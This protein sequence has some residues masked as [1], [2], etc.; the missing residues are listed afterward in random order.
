[1]KKKY[2]VSGR[3]I[4]THFFETKAEARDLFS[5]SR[6]PPLNMTQRSQFPNGWRRPT[7]TSKSRDIRR[8][9]CTETN[10]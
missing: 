6:I 10:F 3:T 5:P 2:A 4:G 7:A 8:A 9:K 1:M